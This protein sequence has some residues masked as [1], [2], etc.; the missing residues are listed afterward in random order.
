MTLIINH[1][2]MLGIK[3]ISAMFFNAIYYRKE[4]K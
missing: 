4:I 2:N 1:N 3:M